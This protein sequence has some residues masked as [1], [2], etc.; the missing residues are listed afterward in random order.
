M[1]LVESRYIP[2][3]FNELSDGL[4][5]VQA[6]Q[7]AGKTER[8]KDLIGGRTLVVGHRRE[9]GV[10]L[11]DRCKDMNFGHYDELSR[12]QINTWTN[13]FICYHSLK[14][15]N[16]NWETHGFDNLVLDEANEVWS[17]AFT[18]RT[19]T[20]NYSR[21]QDLFSKIPRKIIIGAHFPDYVIKNMKR[22]CGA[23]EEIWLG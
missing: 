3:K 4:N 17:K 13:L 18:F 16:R 12:P 23:K 1:A 19:D 22:L 10:Q 11:I 21:F 9:L 15:M 2:I 14:K 8:I 7:G 5:I 6:H 20:T